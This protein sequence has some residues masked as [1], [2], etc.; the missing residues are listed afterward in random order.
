[1][2]EKTLKKLRSDSL[3]HD[4]AILFSASVIVNILNYAFQ[5]YMGRALGPLDY[6]IFA[7]VMS[8]LYIVAVPAS[9]ID[10]SIAKFVSSFK[11]KKEFRRVKHL[12]SIGLKKVIF[13]GLLGFSIITLISPQVSSFLNID[14]TYPIV[15]LGMIFLISL[16][17][18]VG[19]G[20]LLGLQRFKNLGTVQIF[21]S[22]IKLGIG[23][24]LVSLGFGVNG[25]LL[26]LFLSGII[27]FGLIVFLLRDILKQK[28]EGFDGHS[29]MSYSFPVFTALLLVSVMSNID[30]VLVKH[31]FPG[32]EAGHYAAAALLGKVVLF[33]SSAITG[34]MFAKVAELKAI[35]KPTAKLLYESMFYV[36]SIS[37]AVITTYFVAPTFVLNTLFGSS[38]NSAVPLI[39]FFGLAMG[40]FALSCVLIQYN[41]AIK[42]TK[43]IYMLSTAVL[44][45]IIMISSFH[46]SLLT[47][48]KI[49]T[50]TMAFMFSSMLIITKKEIIG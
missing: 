29:I 23:I 43:F 2:L 7:S 45:E 31:Y 19:S 49:L 33:A 16:I 15:I 13:L 5:L 36:F 34:V 11:G 21:N 28:D 18:P 17:G 4:S 38:Y 37:F 27:G 25:A 3:L 10:I 12:F 30:I 35:G 41:L 1:M 26:S 40:F 6:G 32:I 8:L 20:T 14:S 46:D 42:E 24:G 47:V 44:I 9:T 39:G 50:G 48:V 22:F